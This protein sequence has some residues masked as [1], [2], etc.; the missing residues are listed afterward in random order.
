MQDVQE[1]FCKAQCGL[2]FEKVQFEEV[3]LA[4]STLY[5]YWLKSILQFFNFAKDPISDFA[6]CKIQNLQNNGRCTQ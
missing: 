2:K 5:A 1:F 6:F 3:I 4:R